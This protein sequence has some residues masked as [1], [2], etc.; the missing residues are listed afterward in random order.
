MMD[1]LGFWEIMCDYP[2]CLNRIFYDDV[3][4]IRSGHGPGG[5]EFDRFIKMNGWTVERIKHDG[6]DVR[7]GYLFRCNE[8]KDKQEA[9]T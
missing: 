2:E 9:K 7:S 5:K 6:Y 4:G 1:I 3:E 8:H